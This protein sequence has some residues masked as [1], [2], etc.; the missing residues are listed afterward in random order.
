[1]NSP[2]ARL[3]RTLSRL[4]FL[5]DLSRD[6]ERNRDDAQFAAAG[7]E[8]VYVFDENVFEMFVQPFR[9]APVVATF[10]ADIW[11][12]EAEKVDASV[13]ASFE[14][15]SALLT[16]EALLNGTLPGARSPQILLTEPHRFELARRVGDLLQELRHDAGRLTEASSQQLMR[17]MAAFV[18]ISRQSDR[19]ATIRMS[20][21][22][23]ETPDLTED[24]QALRQAG[25]SAEALNRFRLSR[26]VAENLATDPIKEP[27]EQLRR[28]AGPE[29]RPRISSLQERFPLRPGDRSELERGAENWYR[30]L[31]SELAQ[32]L[33][34]R[35]RREDRALWNDAQALSQLVMTARRALHEDI[36]VVMVTADAVLF[37]A[38][39]RR[40]AAGSPDRFDYF[41]P[42]V[43]RRARQYAPIFNRITEDPRQGDA[44]E[45]QSL[46][47]LVQESLEASLVG[48]SLAS[49]AQSDDNPRDVLVA[50]ARERMALKAVDRERLADDPDLAPLV[51]AMQSP[52]WRR[53][54]DAHVRPM[55]QRWQ[56]AQRAVIGASY[57]CL[58]ARLNPDLLNLVQS[59]ADK[60]VQEQRAAIEAYIASL[61][62]QV[63]HDGLLLWLPVASEF[64]GAHHP[65]RA[66][67]RPR[68]P[69]TMRLRL[70]GGV[71][72]ADALEGWWANESQHGVIEQIL[73]SEHQADLARRPDLV[74]AIAGALALACQETNEAVRFSALAV[75][76]A[77]AN[78]RGDFPVA[79]DDLL[80]HTFLAALTQR[81][82]IGAIG[83][84]AHHQRHSDVAVRRIYRAHHEAQMT[85]RR[86]LAL[87]HEQRR[88]S[89]GGDEV[90]LLQIRAR[91]EQSGLSLFV[92]AQLLNADT[93][94]PVNLLIEN[95]KEAIHQCFQ[96]E[97]GI[98]NEADP[99]L[100]RLRRQYVL[101]VAAAE[102]L[103]AL[104]AESGA[105]V[106]D[107]RLNPYLRAVSR[108]IESLGDTAPPLVKAEYLAFRALAGRPPA[109]S[110]QQFKA[111]RSQATKSPRLWLDQ[112]LLFQIFDQFGPL[113]VASA[114]RQSRGA[115]L[116]ESK[117]GS[118][119]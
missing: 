72:L 82:Q 115:H 11:T 38:Y 112:E 20:R 56:R 12:P 62:D 13:W 92:A 60:G 85:L 96:L 23:E 55:R 98:E 70:P 80:E 41:E 19:S 111:I 51:A 8:I 37:D 35:R 14:A 1:M 54:H 81:F 15:Q 21:S 39:R 78:R 4:L 27:L 79:A 44:D 52:E 5:L 83:Q 66:G 46:A 113:R 116:K 26:M 16:A 6:V 119:E 84:S 59:I 91:S 77:Q 34:R 48:L 102:V 10:Y 95:A 9:F 99:F 97:R 24:V 64:I 106:F 25:A 43:L 57:E 87:L 36:R 74:F 47:A 109:D 69:L 93:P 117:S 53:N 104:A 49:F 29:L 88:N 89:Q 22:D 73:A 33:H 86:H 65:F 7:K 107:V 100:Q 18:E 75:E 28:I 17:R 67:E 110:A 42:F 101:N 90:L 31:L 63:T 71:T 68:V 3:E 61:I 94:Q 108:V 2:D 114:R 50:R 30:R 58:S 105:Y 103:A 118:S 76:A 45:G 32:P 40:H